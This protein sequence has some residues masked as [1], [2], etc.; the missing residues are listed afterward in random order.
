[1]ETETSVTS[2]ELIDAPARWTRLAALGLLLAGVA[3]LFMLVSGLLF[4]M[5][6]G[7]EGPFFLITSAIGLVGAFLVWRFGTWSKIVGIVAS[8]LVL[9]ALWWTVFGL[10]TPQSVFDFAPALSVVPGGL[11]ALVSS[12]AALVAGRRGHRTLVA[13]GGERR[14][15]RIL[16]TAV[17]GLAAISAVLTFAGR[18][19]VDDPGDATQVT[20]ANFEFDSEDITVEGGGEVYVKNEDAF[21]HTFTID[22][23]EVDEELVGG[24]EKL[25]SIPTEPGTYVVYCRPHTMDP[26]NPGEDDMAATITVE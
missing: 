7:E 13:E 15:I 25:V 6:P 5:D 24:S 12:I 18:S 3:P 11:V 21:L 14:G 23:L 19:T 26:E 2:P 10:F 1:V 16:L 20:L 9:G 8:V 22:D 17:L 4:G